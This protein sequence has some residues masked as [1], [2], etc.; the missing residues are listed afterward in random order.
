MARTGAA[1]RADG[2]DDRPEAKLLDSRQFLSSRAGHG[3][4]YQSP[5]KALPPHGRRFVFS[6]MHEQIR[7]RIPT[8]RMLRC[9]SATLQSPRTVTVLQSRVSTTAWNY[10]PST[11]YRK[12]WSPRPMQSGPRSGPAESRTPDDRAMAAEAEGSASDPSL[13]AGHQH[14]AC[15]PL[16]RGSGELLTTENPITGYVEVSQRWGLST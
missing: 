13:P 14:L 11:S 6:M 5:A 3:A 8:T 16:R 15:T 12:R 9:A 10:S 4:I 7:V 1:F 2:H